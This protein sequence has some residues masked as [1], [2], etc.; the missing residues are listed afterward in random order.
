MESGQSEHIVSLVPEG[1]RANCESRAMQSFPDRSYQAGLRAKESPA[2][3]TGSSVYEPSFPT[4]FSTSSSIS[5]D[6][7]SDFMAL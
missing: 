6:W 3:Y 2:R 1:E 4:A 5:P 7:T